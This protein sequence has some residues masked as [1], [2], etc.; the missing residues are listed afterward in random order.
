MNMNQIQKQRRQHERDLRVAR[1]IIVST[2]AYLADRC[3]WEEADLQDYMD[4]LVYVFDCIGAG[5]ESL[6]QM[7]KNL[8]NDYGLKFDVK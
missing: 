8:E 2:M 4:S 6:E 3:G 1:L 5:N 7:I